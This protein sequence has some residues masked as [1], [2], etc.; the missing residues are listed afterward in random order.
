VN[1]VTVSILA[2]DANGGQVRVAPR[3]MRHQ[4]VSWCGKRAVSVLL[5]CS[6]FR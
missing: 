5:V 2:Q 4:R 6:P 1:A 3:G